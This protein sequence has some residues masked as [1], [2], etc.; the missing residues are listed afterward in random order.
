LA[1][2]T[3]ILFYFVLFG[4]VGFFAFGQNGETF[5]LSLAFIITLIALLFGDR[6]FLVSI[7][8][9]EVDERYTQLFFTLNK[10]MTFKGLSKVKLYKANGLE[11]NFYSLHPIF[12]TPSIIIS[13]EILKE[14]DHEVLQ[15]GLIKSLSSLK[16]KRLRLSN[17]ISILVSILMAPKYVLRNYELSYLE[18]IY[19]YIFVPLVFLKEF[20]NSETEGKLENLGREVG[21]EVTTL[22]YLEKFPIRDKGFRDNLAKDF[23]VF[24]RSNDGLWT[25]S[26]G[27][28]S[29]I[30]NRSIKNNEI[31]KPT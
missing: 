19:S 27:G 28:F 8:A 16:T 11:P 13:D 10:E 18:I 4:V 21:R 2:I 25:S 26:F 14:N 3:V 5:G 17:F 29:E 6:I 23:R 31:K 7:R 12:S 1:S 30:R 20:V 15:S 9:K 24:N 22:F